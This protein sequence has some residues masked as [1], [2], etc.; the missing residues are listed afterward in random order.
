MILCRD[1]GDP[2]HSGLSVPSH[3]FYAVN[4]YSF[5]ISKYF[6]EE[7]TGGQKHFVVFLSD[8]YLHA[9]FDGLSGCVEACNCRGQQ[10][11]DTAFTDKETEVNAIVVSSLAF[12]AC[13][14]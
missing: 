11:A 14:R 2:V 13:I 4:L 12:Y 3:S 10:Y 7:G 6:Q 5:S 8:A 1:S 9:L